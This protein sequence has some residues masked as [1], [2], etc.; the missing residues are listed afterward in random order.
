MS[1]GEGLKKNLTKNFVRMFTE[2]KLVKKGLQ[3]V[4]QKEATKTIETLMKGKALPS[5]KEIP[6][7]GYNHQELISMMENRRKGDLNPYEGKVK[8]LKFNNK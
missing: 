6:E 4:L 2:N 8:I 1:K 5:I 7:K 3:N